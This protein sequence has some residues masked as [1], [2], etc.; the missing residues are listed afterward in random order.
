MVPF[1]F[2]QAFAFDHTAVKAVLNILNHPRLDK[3]YPPNP[4]RGV[5]MH[6]K[7]PKKKSVSQCW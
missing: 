1:Y 7:A 5:K 3:E 4:K 2:V 6:V